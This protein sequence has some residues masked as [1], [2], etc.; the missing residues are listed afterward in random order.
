MF[1]R[2]LTSLAN[3]IY[4]N[5]LD[6]LKLYSLCKYTGSSGE[7]IKL[8]AV[9]SDYIQ[10]SDFSLSDEIM[11]ILKENVNIFY[12]NMNS[13]AYLD[14]LSFSEFVY[15]VKENLKSGKELPEKFL[16]STI[17]IK[18]VIELYNNKAYD[19][20][21]E[22]ISNLKSTTTFMYLPEESQ[23]VIQ[24]YFCNS[25]ARK[26]SP[27]FESNVIYFKET[28]GGQNIMCQVFE[29]LVERRVMEEKKA[30]ARRL[31]ARGK[32]TVEEIAEDADLPIEVVRDLAGLQL[33]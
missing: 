29:D 11:N 31:I 18:S 9:I 10:R 12:N 15:Y 6:N 20:V 4:K 3:P 21:I 27:E 24:F 30:F 13:P 17:Y 25:L 33:V 8:N 19:R 16:Y 23:R 28:E 14:Y 32:Q 5:I 7:Y 22:I 2:F 26:N 1:V